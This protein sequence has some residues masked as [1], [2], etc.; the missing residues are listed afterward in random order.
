MRIENSLRF[1]LKSLTGFPTED[2]QRLSAWQLIFL[3]SK[4]NGASY[5][6]EELSQ[7]RWDWPRETY[8]QK[9]AKLSQRSANQTVNDSA[10]SLGR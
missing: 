10:T 6:G 9:R 3:H 4:V 7:Y 2:A 5:R 1:F 8:L